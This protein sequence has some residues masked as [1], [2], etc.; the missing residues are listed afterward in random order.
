MFCH[1]YTILRNI[2]DKISKTIYIKTNISKHSGQNCFSI[3]HFRNFVWYVLSFYTIL[4][5][6]PDKIV[7]VY[8][9]LEILSG[10]FCHLYTILRNIPDK[11]DLIYIYEIK[12][13]KHTRQ[14]FYLKYF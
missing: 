14:K 13:I 8:I 1:L 11:F 12:F 4:R 5:N 2:P 7:I 6:I 3:Y 10:M 9:D